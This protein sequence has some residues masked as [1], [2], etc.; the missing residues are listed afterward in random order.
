M[1]AIN[2]ALNQW[3]NSISYSI[4]YES[5]CYDCSTVDD[6]DISDDHIMSFMH[7]VEVS[8]ITSMVM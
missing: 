2:D 6:L 5:I 7:F 1:L 3:K 4:G 8:S